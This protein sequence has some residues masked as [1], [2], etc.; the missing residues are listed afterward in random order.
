MT[1]TWRAVSP[2]LLLALGLSGILWA[3]INARI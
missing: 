3:L 2:F 1:A